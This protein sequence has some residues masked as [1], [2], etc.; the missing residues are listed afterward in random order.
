MTVHWK[1][2]ENKKGK[3]EKKIV[4]TFCVPKKSRNYYYF[5]R[6]EGVYA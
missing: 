2:K 6:G 3:L 4:N 1:N 5:L